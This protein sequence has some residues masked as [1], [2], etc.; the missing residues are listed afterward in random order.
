[1]RNFTLWGDYSFSLIPPAINGIAL[2]NAAMA[3][4][5]SRLAGLLE[6]KSAI[7]IYIFA[8]ISGLFL[9]LYVLKVCCY[10]RDWVKNDLSKPPSAS[11]L[12]A[13]AIALS[14][15]ASLLRTDKIPSKIARVGISV[16]AV[17][18]LIAAFNFVYVCIKT[19]TLPEPFYNTAIHSITITSITGVGVV[20][21]PIRF[22]C[23]SMGMIG[24]MLTHP[25]VTWRLFFNTRS[26]IA[27]DHSVAIYQAAP[28]I[29]CVGW[30]FSPLTGTLKSG[31]GLV[32]SNALFGLV[33]FALILTCY[34]IFQRRIVMFQSFTKP[35]P[36]WA[37]FTF[38]F[39]I[40]TNAFVV[41]TK[42][43]WP[44]SQ[45]LI[46]SIYVLLFFVLLIVIGVDIL[47][48]R[49]FFFCRQF[50]NPAEPIPAFGQNLD[51]E[52]ELAGVV[53]GYEEVEADDIESIDNPR[54]E[55]PSNV[56]IADEQEYGVQISPLEVHHTL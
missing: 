34:A 11:T 16:A 33:V 31:M 26:M 38:P 12:G 39:A 35:D 29:V 30:H 53:E 4:L 18:Q 23:L 14:L 52:V 32:V 3:V 49:N 27:N 56:V 54:L 40:T 24:L 36:F 46:Y 25:V 43:H 42:A 15:L 2:G 37:A 48:A 17:I 9:L 10:F 19:K 7:P 8:T 47:Y 44:N 45:L 6:L 50:E 55:V 5:W 20:P 1:M 22:F 21:L 51:M 13:L 28:S 41:Y